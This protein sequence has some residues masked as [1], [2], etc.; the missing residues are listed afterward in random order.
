MG[1]TKLMKEYSVADI[2]VMPSFTET[3]GLVYAEALSQGLPIIYTKNEGFDGF[4]SNGEIGK[5]VVAGNI[6]DIVN[7]IK[8][9]I[10][11][12]NT[13]QKRITTI[14]F[15]KFNWDKISRIYLKHYQTIVQN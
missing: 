4:F 9:I 7:G 14:D 15:E 5:A 6:G 2:F 8:Y 12:Y 13:I 11:N 3:F 10:H 1:C